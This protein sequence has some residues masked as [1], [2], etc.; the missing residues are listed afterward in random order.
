MKCQRKWGRELRK[1]VRLSR[2]I[3]FGP[4]HVKLSWD[5]FSFEKVIVAYC[6]TGP[7]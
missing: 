1:T 7:E 2:F 3:R 5:P 6:K 4:E